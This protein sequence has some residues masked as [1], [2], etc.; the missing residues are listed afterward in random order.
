MNKIL[1]IG[2]AWVGD[3]MMAQVLFQLL[4]Q[5][6]PDCE[7]HVLAPA[8]SEALL[9]R[10]PEIKK[11]I[12]LPF[13]HGQLQLRKRFQFAKQLRVEK[14]D[15][16]IVLPNSLKSALIPYFAGIPKRAGWLGEYRFGLL[17]D[18]RYL[19]KKQFPKMV[20]RFA[21]LAFP[22]D[23]FLSANLPIPKLVIQKEN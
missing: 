11:S 21:A 2:P 20:E 16:A 12:I 18:V 7:L 13:G 10:M 22:R 6:N 5:Q 8:W 9:S 14:Y 23:T 3:M 1:I 15:Q 4:R 17:N 19:N